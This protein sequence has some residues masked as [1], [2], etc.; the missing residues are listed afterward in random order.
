VIDSSQIAA[1]KPI[2]S[3]DSENPLGLALWRSI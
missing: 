2:I 1:P 3:D